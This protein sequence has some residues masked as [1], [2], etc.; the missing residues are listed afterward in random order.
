MTAGLQPGMTVKQACRLNGVVG[1][2]LLRFGKSAVLQQIIR[3]AF[4]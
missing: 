2:S 3:R 4:M 1:G